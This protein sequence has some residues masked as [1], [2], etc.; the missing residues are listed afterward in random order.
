[1]EIPYVVVVVGFECR[2]AREGTAGCRLVVELVA[3][4]SKHSLIVPSLGLKSDRLLGRTQGVIA[5]ASSEV[6]QR[7]VGVGLV[8]IGSR[9]GPTHGLD[10]FIELS[11]GCQQE[12]LAMQ[13]TP[14]V[15]GMLEAR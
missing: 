2:S 10:R 9:S 3:H 7:E 14:V 13:E 6:E 1:L 11:D 15:G 12:R 5:I 4:D 8:G